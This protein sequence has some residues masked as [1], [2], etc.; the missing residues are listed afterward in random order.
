MYM[1]DFY[2]AVHREREKQMQK[3]REKIAAKQQKKER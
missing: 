3:I 2:C 1:N